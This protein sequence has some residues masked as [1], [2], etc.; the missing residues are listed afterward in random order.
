MLSV[1][2]HVRGSPVSC[3]DPSPR[4]PRQPGQFSPEIAEHG[5]RRKRRQN[6]N[7]ERRSIRKP[8]DGEVNRTSDY[9]TSRRI[10]MTGTTLEKPRYQGAFFIGSNPRIGR[11]NAGSRIMD[12]PES[13]VCS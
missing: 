7:E 13:R 8:P 5:V 10:H 2:L 1:R 3:D 6:E 4:G 9:L 11:T 12:A